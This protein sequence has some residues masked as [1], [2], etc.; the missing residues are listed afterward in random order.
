MK[1]YK[2]R[3]FHSMVR[4]ITNVLTGYEL[5]VHFSEI[6]KLCDEYF[7][8]IQK[9]YEMP[10]EELTSRND[11]DM[12]KIDKI[13]ADLISMDMSIK[14]LFLSDLTMLLQYVRDTDL[15]K[16]FSDVPLPSDPDPV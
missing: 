2:N 14:T 12:H 7:A 10:I 1:T 16:S 13:T 11:D 3:Q 6:D 8:L 15:R 9:V 4:T 5:P